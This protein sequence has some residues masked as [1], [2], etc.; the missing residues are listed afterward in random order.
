MVAG[1]RGE[2]LSMKWQAALVGALASAVIT[3]AAFAEVHIVNDPGGEVS[4]YVEKFHELRKAGEHL[5]I[6][7]PCL[8]ACTLFT[9]I[10]PHDHV[11]VTKRAVLGFHAASYFDDAR[12]TLVPT[13]QGTQVI[14]RLYPPEIQ[15]WIERHGGLTAHIMALRGKELDALYDMCPEERVGN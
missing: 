10:I 9:G 7:G 8:S 12:H 2:A 13:R 14:M 6:D 5:V 3:S 15:S 1:E 4:E 11:C